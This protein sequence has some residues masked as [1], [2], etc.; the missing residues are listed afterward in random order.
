MPHV[1][2]FLE[3]DV[4]QAAYIFNSPLHREHD[5]FQGCHGP[6]QKLMCSHVHSESRA[7]ERPEPVHRFQITLLAGGIPECLP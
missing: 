1:G 3:S 4:P 6:V 2:S 7:S 5:L